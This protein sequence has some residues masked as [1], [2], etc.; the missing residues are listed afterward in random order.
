[1]TGFARTFGAFLE[2]TRGGFTTLLASFAR[3]LGASVKTARGGF[4]PFATRFLCAIG[5]LL[6]AARR[7]LSAFA[8]GIARGCAAGELSGC[9]AIIGLV[10]VVS[11]DL[12]PFANGDTTETGR[13]REGSKRK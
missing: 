3:A 11:H 2:A 12:P 13:L 6:E 8:P 5:T 7:G 9:V 4:A 1:M 10:R